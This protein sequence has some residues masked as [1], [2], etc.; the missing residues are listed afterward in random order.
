MHAT[1]VPAVNFGTESSPKWYGTRL[2]TV[3]LIRNDGSATFIERD[4]LELDDTQG[5]REGT[6]ERRYDFNVQ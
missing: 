2:A 6:G 1:L 5:W 4:I 3:V